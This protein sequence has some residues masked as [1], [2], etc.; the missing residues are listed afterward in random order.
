MAAH[1]LVAM[2]WDALGRA[3]P[4]QAAWQ[5]T[6]PASHAMAQLT[7]DERPVAAGLETGAPVMVLPLWAAAA[8][9]KRRTAEYFI[10]AL[11]SV[12]VWAA[13]WRGLVQV[14]Q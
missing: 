11:R 4:R 14:G 13:E 7:A 9:A 1:S 6:S 12:Y 2:A 3:L 8:A 5:L 10:M